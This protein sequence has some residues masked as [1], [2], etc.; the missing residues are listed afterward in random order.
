ML[1]TTRPRRRDPPSAVRRLGR[2]RTIRTGVRFVGL[3]L[4]AAAALAVPAARASGEAG[5]IVYFA[6]GEQLASVSR[7]AS[8]LEAT[9]RRL[10]AGP[11]LVERR[12]E[13]RT[14]IPV[15][16]EL[17]STSVSAGVATVDLGVG[18]VAG[19]RP[20][21]LRARLAQVVYTATA[22]HGVT[23]VRLLI[24]GG[25]PLGLFPGVNAAVQLTPR[26]LSTPNVTAP[27]PVPEP[28]APARDST[29]RYQRRLA[30]LGYL[31]PDH[32]DGRLGPLTRTAVIGFQKWTGLR[33]DGRLGGATRRALARASRPKPIRH[34]ESGSRF[35]VLLDRQL[36]LAIRNGRVVRA[37]PVSTGKRSTPT[38]SGSFRVV[39]KH[40]R[41]WSSPFGEW[42]LWAV[43][44]VGGVAFYQ[45][46][47]VPP[48]ASSH[49]GVRVPAYDAAW[50]YRFASVG[51]R[52]A[53]IA[54][55][56]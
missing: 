53:V 11:S 42:L 40:A 25:V 46:P 36:V 54:R 6:Q 14:Y 39:T 31:A 29:R 22:M 5:S 24:K 45:S 1:R 21:E 18:F 51:T 44:F 4:V 2:P 35:E 43:P 50:L 37:V 47:E 9:L 28:N 12:R 23:S 20:D 26:S 3:T 33:P 16:T 17:R 48:Q 34:G 7:P 49:G 32:V 19:T 10:L 30:E 15:G 52:V 38:P 55:S 41:W 8:S 56:R 13:L 27:R